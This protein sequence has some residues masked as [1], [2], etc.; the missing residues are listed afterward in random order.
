MSTNNIELDGDDDRK[1]AARSV[2]TPSKPNDDHDNADDDN[3]DDTKSK[4]I[5]ANPYYSNKKQRRST[6]EEENDN[7]LMEK[8]TKLLD[9]FSS[10]TIACMVCK[11]VGNTKDCVRNE[12]KRHKYILK[13]VEEMRKV[14]HGEAKN[15]AK[16]GK[17]IPPNV[18]CYCCGCYVPVTICKTMHVE[19]KA[20]GSHYYRAIFPKRCQ[21][22]DILLDVVFVLVEVYGVEATTYL[23]SDVMEKT[24]TLLTTKYCGNYLLLHQTVVDL[25]QKFNVNI[26]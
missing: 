8:L 2:V 17:G 20:D 24:A 15:L 5:L 25:C 3:D 7:G 13:K 23:G 18:V 21:Y 16:K 1:L 14:V 10:K 9:T 6:T 19:Y 11:V 22:P 12:L 4:K 26:G